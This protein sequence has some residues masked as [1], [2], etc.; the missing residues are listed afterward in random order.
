MPKDPNKN[1]L[2][3]LYDSKTLEDRFSAL[4]H[5]IT[6][7]G[8]D[9]VLYSFAPQLSHLAD[10][11]SPV[12]QYSEKYSDL[13]SNYQKHNYN[14]NDFIIRLIKEGRLSAIDW[15]Y[16][17]Q[18]IS[19]SK[20]EKE[21][22]RVCREI[23]GVTKGLTFPTLSS[24]MGFAG[25][26]IISFSETYIHK[27]VSTTMLEHL[28]ICSEMYHDHTMAHQDARYQFILPILESLTPKKKIVLKHLISGQPMKNITE[29]ADITI[30]DAE[31]L[32]IELR[33]EFGNISKNELIY[34]LG[35]LNI[36]EHL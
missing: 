10:S 1:F 4:E 12:F 21:V 31:K 25:V 14:E 9:A 22:N 29:E 32:L 11:I 24:D 36:T 3:R 6:M 23:F 26:S 17:T 16:E 34:F 7:S 13:L 33:K 19:L 15:W 20:E 18:K 35:L 5:E 30:R 28:K 2:Q 27:E 8:F